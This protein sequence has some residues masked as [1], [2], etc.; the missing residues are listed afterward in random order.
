[1]TASTELILVLIR[2]MWQTKVK[3]HSEVFKPCNWEKAGNLQ[4]KAA[5]FE[6]KQTENERSS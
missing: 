1:M 4:K 6:N 3:Y 2:D 5:S